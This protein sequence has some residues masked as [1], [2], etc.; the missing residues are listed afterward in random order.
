MARLRSFV[1]NRC[2]FVAKCVLFRCSGRPML[3]ACK[4]ERSR[5]AQ[6]VLG[7]V[8]R[9]GRAATSL[10]ASCGCSRSR[11]T[12]AT[13]V[14]GYSK[15]ATSGIMHL[16]TDGRAFAYRDD[17]RYEE[18]TLA[19]ALEAAFAGWEEVC[20]QPRDPDAVRALLERHRAP[21]PEHRPEVADL[22]SGALAQ[23]ERSDWE[24][25]I[26]L[27]GLDLVPGFMWMNEIELEDGAS[28]HAYKNI[29][30]RQYVHLARDGRAFAFR[31]GD[32]YERCHHSGGRAGVQRVGGKRSQPKHADA[33]RALLERH[34]SGELHR[35]CTR[36]TQELCQCFRHAQH[37]THGTGDR[38]RHRACSILG[39]KRLP[40]AGPQPRP[41]HPRV[42]GRDRRSP[43]ART[44]RAPRRS[45][46]HAAASSAASRSISATVRP[47]SSSAGTARSPSASRRASNAS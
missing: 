38:R 6:A 7:A 43:H 32:R 40:S 1:A 16:A 41:Q 44:R 33:V 14:H 20:P 2:R 27:V 3:R 31:T 26:A 5:G 8:G 47:N 23:F 29:A 19:T 46:A 17:E 45:N 35:K 42:Q 25:L 34:R 36:N 10:P 12:T 30:T 13:E 9:A 28:V 4:P 37:R 11:S 15:I 21:A 18:I 39:P 22:M 24:P